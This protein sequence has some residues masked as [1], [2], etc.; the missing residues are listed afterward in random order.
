MQHL[1]PGHGGDQQEVVGQRV[2]PGARWRFLLEAAGQVAVE[3]IG[4]AGDQQTEADE[5]AISE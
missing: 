2:E 4:R 5:A 1:D 3:K